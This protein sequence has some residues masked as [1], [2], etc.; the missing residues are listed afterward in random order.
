MRKFFSFLRKHG[1]LGTAKRVNADMQG[2]F[3]KMPSCGRLF[4]SIDRFLCLIQSY[5]DSSFDRKYG[6]DA[7]GIIPLKD[8]TIE[9]KNAE[10]GV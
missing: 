7:S 4:S 6:I 3:G 1:P 2:R 5:F 8:L 10:E 9:S